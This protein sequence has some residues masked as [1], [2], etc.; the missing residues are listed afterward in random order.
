MTCT[1]VLPIVI[2]FM[3]AL[4]DVFC[5]FHK[6]NGDNSIHIR[7]MHYHFVSLLQ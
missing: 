3:I 6:S 4:Y 2:I 1:H 7:V 5:T